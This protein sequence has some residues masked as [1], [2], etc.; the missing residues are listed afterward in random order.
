LRQHGAPDRIAH[1]A[2]EYEQ[3]ALKL[4]QSAN[5]RKGYRAQLAKSRSDFAPFQLA[6]Q[7]RR[8]DAAI[9]AAYAR[10]QQGLPPADITIE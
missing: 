9:G 1:N 8:F 6:T 2:S 4:M 3:L 7:A 10:Y 5:E